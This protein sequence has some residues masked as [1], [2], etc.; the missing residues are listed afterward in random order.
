LTHATPAAFAT[1]SRSRYLENDI[2]SQYVDA[3]VDVLLSGG[4][5]H[6]IPES[7]KEDE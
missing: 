3:D 6:W 4:L 7:V 1:H 5:R 2:A